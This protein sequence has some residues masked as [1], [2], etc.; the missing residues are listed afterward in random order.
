MADPREP[1]EGEDQHVEDQDTEGQEG[2]DTLEAGEQD[3]AADEGAD[4]TEGS[5]GDVEGS[6]DDEP[7]ARRPNRA[8]SRIQ[9]LT[10]TAREA[11]ER[12]ER[13]ERELQELR[14]DQRRRDQQTQGE[15]PEER[16]ARRALM[17]PMEVMREDLKESEQRTQRLLQ[18]QMLE[19]RE[20]NDKLAYQTVMRDA[21]HLKK[22]DAEVEKVRKENQDNGSFVPREVILDYVIGR[23]ARAAATRQAPKAKKDGQRRIEAQQSKPAGA[24]GDTA[25]ARGKQGDS[26]ESRLL[27]VPI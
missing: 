13:V 6:V 10:Q 8:Q 5:E 17:D 22:Y 14:A 16:A 21:P 27:N 4:E 26:P 3:A 2:D 11:K 15:K 25:T 1:I 12:A 19:S 20:S 7:P 18:Q 9:S 23:A 24:R